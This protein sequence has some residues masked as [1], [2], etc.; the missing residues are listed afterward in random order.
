MLLQFA[1]RV[2]NALVLGVEK[3][4]DYYC[5]ESSGQSI[6]AVATEFESSL[7]KAAPKFNID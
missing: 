7:E 3:R 6:T 1:S 2:N 4:L 5:L